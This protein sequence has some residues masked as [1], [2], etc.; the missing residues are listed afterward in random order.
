M[1]KTPGRKIIDVSPL[2]GVFEAQEGEVQQIIGKTGMGKTYEGTRRA[3]NYLRQG[4]VVYTS[5]RLNLPDYYDER[6][7]FW[8]VFRNL[9]LRRKNFFRFDYKE[10]WKHV[11]LTQFESKPTYE[12]DGITVKDSGG[13]IDTEALAK[14]LATRTDCIF[15][16]D[17]GQDVFDSNRKSGQIARQSITRTRHM[18]K[19]LIL[20]SQRAQAVD[21][22]VRANCTYF[23]LCEKRTS[24][25]FPT[26]FRVYRTDD[27]DESSNYPIWVRHN[28]QGEVTWKA[29]IWYSAWA[30][31]YIYD[32]YDSWYMRQSM[33][34]SQDLKIDAYELNFGEKML[35]LGDAVLGKKKPKEKPLKMAINKDIIELSTVSK[36]PPAKPR[37]R[38]L[39]Q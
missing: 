21:V 13:I 20:I 18:H 1:P 30:K 25:I 9:L 5:W 39:V 34:R 4:Y 29:P 15:M 19:T 17:E 32:A 23:Y 38:F 3:L 36:L 11:D 37:K 14:F 28:S 12:K 6:E 35:A 26:R 7:H 10:N 27:V 24:V 33:I 8:P 16:L 22:N 31:Q 2:L